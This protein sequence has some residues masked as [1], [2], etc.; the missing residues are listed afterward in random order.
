MV[1]G[2]FLESRGKIKGQRIGRKAR[3]QHEWTR[4]QVYETEQG[5]LEGPL[6]GKPARND[7]NQPKARKKDLGCSKDGRPRHGLPAAVKNLW[8]ELVPDPPNGVEVPGIPGVSFKQFSERN[9]EIIHRPGR[10]EHVI[11]PDFLQNLLA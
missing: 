4:A 3:F 10:R 2:G 9:D 5:P 8:S 11:A 7:W 6:R 1:V